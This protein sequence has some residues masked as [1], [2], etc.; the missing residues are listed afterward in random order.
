[1]KTQDNADRFLEEIEKRLSGAQ[2]NKPPFSRFLEE[3]MD[4]FDYS[5]TSLA[6]KVFHRVEKK[7]EG[8]AR[9]VPVTRQTIGTWL[10]G[11]MPSSREI[12]ITLGMAFGMS[13][14]EINYI[15]LE[16][17]MGYGLYCKNI[18]DALWIALIGG[19]FSID[20]MENV[21]A[22]IEEILTE[23]MEPERRSLATTDLWVMLSEARSLDQ[24][25]DLVR[26]YREEFR[27]GAKR[28]GQC[29][30]E[31]IEEE[32]GYYEKAT[33]FLRDIGCLHYEAQFSKVKAGKAVVTREWLLRF[34]IAL[35]PSLES[36]QK[37]L[38]KA[39]MEPLG[40]TPAEIIIGMIAKY[41]ADS[42]ADS[43]K[44]WMMIE[45]VTKELKKKGYEIEED[46]CRKYDSVYEIPASQKW[47][48]S[49][50]VGRQLLKN[51]KEKDLGYDKN[52]YCRYIMVDRV[53][54]DDMNRNKKSSNFKKNAAAY[55]GVFHAPGWMNSDEI[56]WQEVPSLSIER[57]F[58][59]DMFDLE[60]FED[61][62][63]VRRPSRFSK[64]FIMNDIYFYSSLLYSIWTG[65]CFQKDFGDTE[66]EELRAEFRQVGLDADV[67]LSILCKNL[68]EGATYQQECDISHILDAFGA[69]R[70]I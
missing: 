20:E 19:L 14:E 24:F 44:I 9:Y 34:C 42:V 28:F 31:V 7:G 30:E 5:N 47:W 56:E 37:L 70:S 43:Q 1:M 23:P 35:Q 66:M 10:K 59:P 2:E 45:S 65:K 25:Y 21:K 51:Q 52:G 15:L 69:V 48:F 36:I 22:E 3:K 18:E 26:T 13:L 33:W 60:K 57:G 61:Y 39:Q 64:D 68:Q 63:Y 50:C 12:Y 62:C 41:K 46:L 54:F 32:Y 40:I 27:D 6:K 58:Q 67:L 53:L 38:A 49:A 16:R 29:L 55:M 8:V 11:S 17:Y 4:Q